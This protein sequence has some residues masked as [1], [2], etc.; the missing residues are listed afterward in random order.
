MMLKGGRH[1][2][3]RLSRLHLKADI[4]LYTSGRSCEA[5]EER[6]ARTGQIDHNIRGTG[7]GRCQ[8]LGGYVS[9]RK[10]QSCYDDKI[11]GGGRANKKPLSSG[12]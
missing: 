4:R 1:G 11:A 10:M 2:P 8:C 5:V 9:Q 7:T 3:T 6:R 12:R